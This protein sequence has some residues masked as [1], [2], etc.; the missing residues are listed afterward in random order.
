MR[1][2][3]VVAA[4]ALVAVL[5]TDSLPAQV[6][7]PDTLTLTLEEAYRIAA[8]NNPAYRQTL[9]TRTLNGPETRATLFD[10]ILPSLSVNALT[11]LYTGRL[12]QQ[13]IDFFGNPIENP[14]SSYTFSSATSQGLTLDWNIQGASLLNYGTRQTL[15]NRDRDLAESAARAELR[16]NVRRQFFAVL[17]ERDL[18]ALER[19]LIE[20]RRVDLEVAQQ[21]F[22]LAQKTRVDVLNAE[23]GIEQQNLAV[24]RQNRLYEQA[25][26]TLRTLLGDAGLSPLRLQAEDHAVFDPSGVDVDALVERAMDA[27]PLVRQ[28]RAFVESASHGLKESRTLWWPS[29]SAS[30][31]FGRFAQ[32][33]GRS[34]L[35]DLTPKNDTRSSFQLALSV[36]FFNNFFQNKASI[37]RANVDLDN[38]DEELRNTRLAAAEQVRVAV[39]TLRNEYESHSL[40]QRSLDIAQEALRLAREEY[41]LGTRTFEQLRESVNAEAEARRQV[42][43]ADYGFTDGLM[44]LEEAVGTTIDGSPAG[45]GAE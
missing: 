27:N 44:T 19:S 32:T 35:F 23:L 38:A 28:R 20:S 39:L 21:L 10:Q 14:E 29:L 2:G 5:S 8:F 11:T 6:L 43:E 18:L 37:A 15:T 45:S 22:R 17:R 36:P 25:L 33:R 13:T 41:R 7:R 3:S 31:T 12:T 4:T 16:A 24:N 9:N 30:Y 42:V 1:P 34:A 40:A 26:L